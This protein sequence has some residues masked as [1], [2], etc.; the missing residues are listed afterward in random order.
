MKRTVA[1]LL[2]V[3][4]ALLPICSF[5][6]TQEEYDKVVSERD[7]LYQQL[8]EAGLVP[9]VDLSQSAKEP[10][11]DESYDGS[12]SEF[13]SSDTVTAAHKEGDYF[14]IAELLQNYLSTP[15]SPLDSA[16]ELKSYFENM[17]DIKERTYW[18]TDFFDG[19]KTLRW[20]KCSTITEDT[21]IAPYLSGNNL[22]CRFG[23]VK[24]DWVFF[25]KFAISLNGEII[26]SEKVDSSDRITD[27][28]KGSTITEWCDID[29]HFN[30]I[31]ADIIE[32]IRNGGT[33]AIRFSN[34]KDEK[35]FDHIFSAD[36]ATTLAD[37]FEFSNAYEKYEDID[38]YYGYGV[39]NIS[40][41]ISKKEDLPVYPL[42]VDTSVFARFV[43]TNYMSTYKALADP[44]NKRNIGETMFEEINI[45]EVHDGYCFGGYD[46][47]I[48]LYP[49]GNDFSSLDTSS[50]N[51]ASVFATLTYLG[52]S[53][54]GTPVFYLG[55]PTDSEKAAI[56]LTA[57][58]YVP[59]K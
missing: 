8:I 40:R 12:Y 9:V 11:P 31:E 23:F 50:Y 35:K 26:F 41:M 28:L 37:Y 30:E 53:A 39:G 6:V 13:L 17:L 21:C 54:Q 36:E 48:L 18:D 2:V 58:N 43:G 55:R 47:W 33:L 16:Y 32:S 5:A 27:V 15:K 45:M 52:Q 49:E 10:V 38:R 22:Y 42:D 24:E 46:K 59:E 7:A 14:A 4:M 19:T 57:I 25:D 3:I 20:M 56:D 1:A 34:S 29:L 51:G 44:E